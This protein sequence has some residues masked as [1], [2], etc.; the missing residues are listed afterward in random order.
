MTL[1]HAMTSLTSL[2]TIA[3]LLIV[4]VVLGAQQPAIYWG[5]E[6][7]PGWR[8]G[9]TESLRT[10][11]ERTDFTR[12]TSTLQLHEYIAQLKLAS[13]HVHVIEMFTSPLRKVAPAIVLSRPRVTSPQQARASGKPVVFLMGNIHPPEPEAMEALLM[14]ARDIAAGQRKHPSTT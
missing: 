4:A 9:W 11:P 8:D 2:S 6:V 13:E 14:V 1:V 12:T 10:V 3:G 5:D 7:P